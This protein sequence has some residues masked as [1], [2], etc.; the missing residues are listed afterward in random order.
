VIGDGA[1]GFHLVEVD[2]GLRHGL[3]MV[4]VVGNDARW[5]AEVQIHR[6]R[7]GAARMIGCDLLSSRYDLA[8]VALGGHGERVDGAALLDGAMTRARASALPACV[9]VMI[10]G[11]PAPLLRRGN[12]GAA[13]GVAAP[14]G[15][16]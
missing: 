13:D 8:A 11:L 10:D 2:S 16:A 5:N 3:P 9:N 12:A 14:A 4:A 7:Y 1:C 6:R 15:A